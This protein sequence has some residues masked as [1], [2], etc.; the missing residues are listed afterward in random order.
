MVMK[1]LVLYSTKEVQTYIRPTIFA[2]DLQKKFYL[3]THSIATVIRRRMAGRVEGNE[4]WGGGVRSNVIQL[5][6]L[7]ILVSMCTK[8]RKP[9]KHQLMQP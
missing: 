7:T 4:L 5:K 1:T 6:V 9:R 8:R 2:T 3:K